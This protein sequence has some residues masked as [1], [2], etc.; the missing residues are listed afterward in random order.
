MEY[1]FFILY[2]AYFESRSAKPGRYISRID[3]GIGILTQVTIV[4]LCPLCVNS[5]TIG[6]TDIKWLLDENGYK[7]TILL[8]AQQVGTVNTDAARNTANKN[9]CISTT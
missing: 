9:E 4:I 5:S 7:T 6:I 1:R 8:P 3:M 2:L